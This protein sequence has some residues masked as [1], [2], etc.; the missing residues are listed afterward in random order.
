MEKWPML[1]GLRWLNG[2]PRYRGIFLL[3]SPVGVFA[4]RMD[5]WLVCVALSRRQ[6]LQTVF[7]SWS[8]IKMAHLMYMVYLTISVLHH[9]IHGFYGICCSQNSGEARLKSSKVR[10]K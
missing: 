7:L 4:L 9:R 1:R 2:S 5:F 3:L 8:C 6:R 10:Q